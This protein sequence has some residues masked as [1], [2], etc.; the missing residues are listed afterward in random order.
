MNTSTLN[1]VP[2]IK[3]ARATY[4]HTVAADFGLPLVVVA[5]E[6]LCEGLSAAG[7]NAMAIDYA[8]LAEDVNDAY[9]DIAATPSI[10]LKQASACGS[11]LLCIT[12]N[13]SDS[14]VDAVERL[15]AELESKAVLVT[16]HAIEEPNDYGSSS[17][18]L[19]EICVIVNSLG[20]V[21]VVPAVEAEAAV[22]MEDVIEVAAVDVAS[23]AE[24]AEIACAEAQSA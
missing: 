18:G 9:K 6:Q 5:N 7:L 14:I 15:Q 13:A 20:A 12:N 24:A 10:F 22:E 8:A 3:E 19:D 4:T 23:G 11:V 16:V 1:R 17:S 2:S 21:E